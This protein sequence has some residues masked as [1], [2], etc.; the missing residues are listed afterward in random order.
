MQTRLFKTKT[1]EQ[2]RYLFTYRLVIVRQERFDSRKEFPRFA[3]V[4]GTIYSCRCTSHVHNVWSVVVAVVVA[5]AA[6][7]LMELVTFVHHDGKWQMTNGLAWR[8]R[9]ACTV[10]NLTLELTR[11]RYS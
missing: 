4:V 9:C 7:A 1:Q 5:A 11:R 6:E 8:K 3:L 10:L 2:I